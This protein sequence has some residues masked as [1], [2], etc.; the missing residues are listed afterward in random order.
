MAAFTNTLKARAMVV[1]P[2][3]A[4]APAPA[5]NVAEFNRLQAAKLGALKT[6]TI[7]PVVQSAHLLTTGAS[8]GDPGAKA[9]IASTVAAARAGNPAAIASAAVLS[10]AQKLQIRQF[11]VDKWVHGLITPA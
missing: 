8:L 2:R 1:A 11:Y 9:V 10:Q 5:Y 7:S 4:P 3:P 6:M